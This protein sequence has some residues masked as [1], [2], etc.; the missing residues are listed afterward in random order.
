MTIR[1]NS[2]MP[3]NSRKKTGATTANSTT[4]A[5]R[6][7]RAGTPR[8]RTVNAGDASLLSPLTLGLAANSFIAFAPSVDRGLK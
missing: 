8:G 2:I 1:P 6:L 5:P 7:F 4:D 3:N